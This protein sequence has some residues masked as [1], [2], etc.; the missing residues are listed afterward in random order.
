MKAKNWL[1]INYF[2]QYAVQG[3]FFQ[4]WLVYLTGVKKLSILEAS[5][6]F[7]MVYLAR[8]LGGVFFASYLI[9]VFGMKKSY[10]IISIGGFLATLMYGFTDSKLSLIV[11]TFLIGITFFTLTPLTETTASIFLKEAGID[12]GKVRVFGSF[13][14]MLIGISVGAVLYYIN[15]DFIYY[16]MVFLVGLYCVFICSKMPKLVDTIKVYGNEN[17]EKNLFLG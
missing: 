13:S 4:Y 8:F 15:N 11:V 2:L 9:R 17:K 12:Y 16:A 6:I 7:S 10:R 3:V 5:G 1:A 14:F